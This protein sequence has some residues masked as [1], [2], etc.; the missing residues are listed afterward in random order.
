MAQAQQWLKTLRQGVKGDYGPGWVLKDQYGRFKIGKAEAGNA[1]HGRTQF[2]STDLLFTRGSHRKVLNLIGE[3]VDRMDQLNIGM[4]D[5]YQ[6]VR[7]SPEVTGV[8]LNWSKVQGR[9]KDSRVGSGTVKPR[10]TP[11][12]RNIESIEPWLS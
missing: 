6:L 2:I 9:Y 12:T 1:R 10:T 11:N 3:L 7:N 5:A 8:D 4:T